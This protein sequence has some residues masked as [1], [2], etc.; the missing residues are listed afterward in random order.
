MRLQAMETLVRIASAEVRSETWLS[1]VNANESKFT[2][3]I[4][5]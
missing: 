2:I 5:D 1:A 3:K 4:S